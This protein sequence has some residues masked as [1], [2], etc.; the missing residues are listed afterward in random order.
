MEKVLKEIYYDLQSGASFTGP[1]AV[2]RAAREKGYKKIKLKQV[3]DWLEKQETYTLHK[4]AAKRYPRNRVIVGG[5]DDQ[6]QADLVDLSS[7]SE[8]NKGYRYLLTVIDI[9]SKYAF[10]IPLKTKTAGELKEAFIKI[11][12]TKRIPKKLQSDHGTEFLNRTLQSYLKSKNVHFFA[13]N[14]ENKASV[15]E[16]F[17]RTLKTKMFRYFTYKNTWN[18]IDVLPAMLKSYNNSYHRSIKMK[19]SQVN[20]KNESTV[21]DTLYGQSFSKPIV[22]FQFNVNDRVRVSRYKRIFSK[23]YER[24]WSIEIFII[25]ERLPR[26]PPV[27]RP[28]KKVKNKFFFYRKLV[29]KTISS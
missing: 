7:L 18:Y 21:W 4:P 9:L 24:N 15:I 16:R 25:S 14:S 17:N 28:I 23:G 27:Y 11:F 6:F 12:K 20:K 1:A 2:L 10:A 29:S 22:R 26:R 5:K 13:T 8:Y 3:K 19:P